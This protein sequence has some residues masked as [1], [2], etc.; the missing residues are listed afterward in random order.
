MNRRRAVVRPI[1]VVYLPPDY[2]DG[3]RVEVEL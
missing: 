2:K 1:D 3:Q